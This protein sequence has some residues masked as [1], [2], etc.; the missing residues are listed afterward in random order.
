MQLTIKD[1]LLLLTLLPKEGDITTI[2]LVQQLRTDLSFSEEEHQLFKFTTREDGSIQWADSPARKD[3]EIGPRAHIMIAD[4]LKKLNTDKKL[5]P[6]FLDLYDAF[7]EA[8]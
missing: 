2:R 8:E 6:D 5:T 4:V 7:V 3:V 1:R